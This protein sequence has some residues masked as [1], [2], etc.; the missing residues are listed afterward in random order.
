MS[1]TEILCRSPNASALGVVPFS[2]NGSEVCVGFIMDD[3]KKLLNCSMFLV[4]AADPDFLS[5][6]GPDKIREQK[7][8]Q[9]ILKVSLENVILKS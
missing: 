4:I 9:L 7:D 3:V 1:S 6:S 8:D 2:S 5:F